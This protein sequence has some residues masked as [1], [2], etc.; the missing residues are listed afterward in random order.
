MRPY[1]RLSP[2]IN[3]ESDSD[4]LIESS[5]RSRQESCHRD[6][7]SQDFDVVAWDDTQSC[8]IDSIVNGD[9][10]LLRTFPVT[11]FETELKSSVSKSALEQR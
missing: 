5:D 9:Y 2:S 6:S 7:Q 10:R 8:G 11:Y 1:V 4:S 3:F